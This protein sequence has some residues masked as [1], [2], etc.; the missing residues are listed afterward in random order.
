MNRLILALLIFVGLISSVNASAQ[1]TLN[2]LAPLSDR[3]RDQIASTSTHRS[4]DSQD[5]SQS[6]DRPLLLLYERNPWLMVIGADS[7]QLESYINR[8][9]MNSSDVCNAF[10]VIYMEGQNMC[11]TIQKTRSTNN[12]ATTMET[13]KTEIEAL[14]EFFVAW[15]TGKISEQDFDTNFLHRFDSEFLLIPPAGVIL[16][17]QDIATSIREGYN[18]NPN[19]RI[20]IRN[21]QV[22]RVFSGYI[23]A[24]YEEWQRNALASTPPDNARLAT[25]LFTDTRP[26]RW[27][28]IHETWMP[29]DVAEAGPYDF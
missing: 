14:H 24:T 6:S 12:R 29:K 20:A 9:G 13:V 2:G 19:F 23:L 4:S 15:F 17:L 22:R 8:M 7:R 1:R 10:V 5:Q 21:V 18:S 11:N 3:D 25:V 26:L 16:S 27:L 28:H